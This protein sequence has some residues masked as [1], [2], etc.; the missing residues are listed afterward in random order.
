MKVSGMKLTAVR[1]ALI[2]IPLAVL[3]WGLS[4]SMSNEGSAGRDQG[5]VDVSSSLDTAHR[6][7]GSLRPI[8]P[9]SRRLPSRGEHAEDRSVTAGVYHSEGPPQLRRSGR[10]S[11]RPIPIPAEHRAELAAAVHSAQLESLAAFMALPYG[12]D[13]ET[14]GLLIEAARL[15]TMAPMAPFQEL[16]G[17]QLESYLNFELARPDNTNT[18]SLIQI[19]EAL[20]EA[21][22]KPRSA[23][24]MALLGSPE[25]ARPARAAAAIALAKQQASGYAAAIKAFRDELQDKVNA[26]N[27]NSDERPFMMDTIKEMNGILQN[28]GLPAP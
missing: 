1:T 13:P 11:E 14:D 6:E 10:S 24:L 3:G 22:D 5:H 4:S 9:A 25:A 7:P 28:S 23:S 16:G 20:T 2:T 21:M 27:V 17:N 12:E 15:L 19:S 26:G 8:M 18:G